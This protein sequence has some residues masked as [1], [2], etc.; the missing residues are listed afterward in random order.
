MQF[1]EGF[2]KGLPDPVE[3]ENILRIFHFLQMPMLRDIC[4]ESR[5]GWSLRFVHISNI[6]L[7]WACGTCISR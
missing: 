7:L 1:I 5:A 2:K 4:N 3:L 6:S